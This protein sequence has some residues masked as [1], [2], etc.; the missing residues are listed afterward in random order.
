MILGLDSSTPV[1]GLGYR[2]SLKRQEHGEAVSS[3]HSLSIGLVIPP[4]F[5]MNL[6][7]ASDR[8]YALCRALGIGTSGIELT[9]A[10]IAR[11]NRF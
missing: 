6:S 4:V 8:L 3:T 10:H 7:Y 9:N 2:Y 11:K 5:R 1:L